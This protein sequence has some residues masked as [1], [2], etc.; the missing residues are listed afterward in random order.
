MEE[1]KRDLEEYFI[2]INLQNSSFFLIIV[3]CDMCAN[4]HT[5]IEKERAVESHVLSFLNGYKVTIKNFYKKVKGRE[6]NVP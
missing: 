3:L 6:K 4:R 1:S 5:S 2:R